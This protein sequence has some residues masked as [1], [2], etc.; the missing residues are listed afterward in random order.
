[1][2]CYKTWKMAE[3]NQ[4][5]SPQMVLTLAKTAGFNDNIRQIYCEGITENEKEIKTNRVPTLVVFSLVY[6]KP[7]LFFWQTIEVQSVML[8]KVFKG[9]SSRCL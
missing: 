4:V 9:F 1:M 6:E 2:C 3:A 7:F 5:P 8:E